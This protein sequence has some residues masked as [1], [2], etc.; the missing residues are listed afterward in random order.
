MSSLSWRSG[1]RALSGAL[2]LRKPNSIGGSPEVGNCSQE[3]LSES[4]VGP[5]KDRRSWRS[6]AHPSKGTLLCLLMYS[7]HKGDPE[8]F[9]T[10]FIT[11]LH[12]VGF[13]WI[14]L[15]HMEN[16]PLFY[17]QKSLTKQMK[18]CEDMLGTYD[19]AMHF[20]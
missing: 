15:H 17:L 16:P 19:E 18:D 6:C 4:H 5:I 9:G 12:F 2:G 1:A 7:Q 3:W 13:M 20:F 10:V 11:T 14:S 8:Y